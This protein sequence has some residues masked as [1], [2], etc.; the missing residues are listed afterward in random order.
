MIRWLG[1]IHRRLLPPEADTGWLPYLLPVYLVF[2]P[3]KYLFFE[4][5]ALE[6]AA[7][8]LTIPVFLALYFNA[9]WRRSWQLVPT[10]ICLGL[11]GTLWAPHRGDR[12]AG[13]SQPHRCGPDRAP[14][15]VALTLTQ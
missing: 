8:V 6:I 4:A 15:G 10:L 12:Q 7:A 11:L 3:A 5:A 14:P 1:V 13:R 2:F 9:Y